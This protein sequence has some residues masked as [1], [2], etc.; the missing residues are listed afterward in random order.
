MNKNELD[1]AI[2]KLGMPPHLYSLNGELI[3]G[4]VMMTEPDGYR[5]FRNNEYGQRSEE[6]KFSTEE[7]AGEYVYSL[8]IAT[9]RLL[10]KNIRTYWQE[11]YADKNK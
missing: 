3:D 11:K 4:I 5:V 1:E 6:E 7:K 10:P 9:T 8:A 2:K